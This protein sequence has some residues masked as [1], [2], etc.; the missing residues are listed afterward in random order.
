MIY[1]VDVLIARRVVSQTKRRL[2]TSIVDQSDIHTK[3][4]ESSSVI[5]DHRNFNLNTILSEKTLRFWTPNLF[6]KKK[7]NF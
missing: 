1:K 7:T 2:Q 4:I 5:F 3:K 6:Y